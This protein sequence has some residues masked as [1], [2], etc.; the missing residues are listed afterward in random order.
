MSDKINWL[1]NQIIDMQSAIIGWRK[2][3]AFNSPEDLINEL[4]RMIEQALKP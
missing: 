2:G 4:E 1:K 3:L